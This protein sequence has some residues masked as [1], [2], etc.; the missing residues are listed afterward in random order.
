M[1][2]EERHKLH[3]NMLAQLIADTAVKIKPYQNAILGGVILAL[4][5]VIVWMYISTESASQASTA[6]TTFTQAFDQGNAAALEKMADDNKNSTAAP[7][8]NLAA[9]DIQLLQGCNNLFTNKSTANQQL[10]KACELYQKVREETSSPILLSQATLGLAKAR[11]SQGKLETAVKLYT[12]VKTNWPNT[13]YA[14]MAS[15][16]L[17]D[18]NKPSTKNVYDQLAKYE[19]KPAFT[20]PSGQKSAFELPEE[21]PVFVPDTST[22]QKAGEKQEPKKEESDNASKEE[23]KED[24]KA[25][26]PENTTNN[27][28]A[29][30]KT[31][32]PADVQK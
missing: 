22:E 25:D 7:A 23:T 4:V 26:K 19:P 28:K 5:V 6:W 2:S 16:R 27:T 3:Q 21:S 13:V 11:E 20:A 17:N 29:E 1:K 10:S 9:A 12:E 18:V 14:K 8:A 15:Q 30:D 32:K 31:D 24:K